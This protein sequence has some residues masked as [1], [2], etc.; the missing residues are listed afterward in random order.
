MRPYRSR[1]GLLITFGCALALSIFSSTSRAQGDLGCCPDAC[2]P[3]QVWTN[4]LF[5]VRGTT[6]G[7]YYSPPKGQWFQAMDDDPTVA[8]GPSVGLT[9]CPNACNPNLR[10]GVEFFAVD[11]WSATSQVAG[12][13][14]VQF[15]SLPYL[16]E[17]VTP[18]VPSSGFGTATFD[19]DSNL[20][21][22]E[23]NLYYQSSCWLTL[24]TGFRW[25]EL[26]EQYD[27]VF[28]TGNTAP[29]Y[30]INT[31]NHLYGLQAGSLVNLHNRGPWRFDGWMKAGLYANSADQDTRE[32][33]TSAGGL[34]ISA[35][36]RSAN[37]AFVGDMGISASRKLTD[38]LNFRAS[39]MCLWLQGVALAPEQLDNTDPSNGIASVDSS[40]GLFY[41]GGFIGGELLW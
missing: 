24:L 36:A 26:G 2:C 35:S 40:H 13:I 10:A 6:G 11:G 38:H 28:A 1:F 39:Y 20:Y 34:A 22:T 23:L 32:D 29:T 27:A 37:V 5:L 33:Y 8:W 9:F 25:I 21:N 19:Y 15:P 4:A 14:S 16:P 12:N 3:V 7:Q 18:G 30:S 31:N 17:L 41:H